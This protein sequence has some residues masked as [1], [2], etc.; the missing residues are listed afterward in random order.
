[1]ASAAGEAASGTAERAWNELREAMAE[2]AQTVV[3]PAGARNALERAEGFR[4][5]TRL[6]SAGLEMHLEK[7]DATHPAFTRMLTPTR[8]FLGDNPDTLYEYVPLDGSLSYRV[9]GRRGSEIYLAFCVYDRDA[10]GAT[11]IGANLSDTE[12]RFEDDGSFEVVLSTAQPWGAKNWLALS[13]RAH[14]MIARQ[15]FRD[16]TWEAPASLEIEAFSQ[17]IPPAPLTEEELAERLACVGR[18]VKETSELSATLSVFAALN[19]IGRESQPALEVVAGE[20]REGGSSARDLAAS[21]DPKVVAGHLPTPD[22]QYTG[23]WWSLEPDEAVIAEGMA[24]LCRYWSIQIFNRWLESPDY[25]YRQVALN[26]SQITLE[27]DGSFRAVLAARNPGVP[28]WIDTAGHT[29]GQ[30]VVRALLA[31][32]ALDVKFRVTNLREVV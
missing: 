16:R 14:S 13:A 2:A 1:M 23:A 5:L 21:I 6:L 27:D 28:N 24:P 26:D 7:A 10:D 17:T 15:Y 11:K 25:R 19:P 22:I 18:F 29:G 32:E 20:L 3:G 8:K 31:K 4:Y 12:M 9:R 30:I